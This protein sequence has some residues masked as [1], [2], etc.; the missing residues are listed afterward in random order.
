MIDN[1]MTESGEVRQAMDLIHG[2][3]MR[4]PT[5]YRPLVEFCMGIPDDQYLRDGNSRWL[6][7]RM[8]RGRV[9]DMVL[10]EKR[11]GLQAADLPLRLGRDRQALIAELDLLGRD[12]AMSERLNLSR[13]KQAIQGLSPGDPGD[14]FG[15]SAIEL[16][17][18]RAIATAR[19]IRFVEGTN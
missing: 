17:L 6:A 2:I 10:N 12:P 14:R 8:L 9:P 16:A 18:P 1:A 15:L 4:D 3:P 7:R 5:A 11:R 19:F 13:L